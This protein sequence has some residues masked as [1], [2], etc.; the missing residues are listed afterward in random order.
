VLNLYFPLG[1]LA[2]WKAIYEVAVR[3]FYWDK[4]AHGLFDQP[5][6]TPPAAAAAERA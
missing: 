1:A 4:T 3:P 2:A 5:A 6:S